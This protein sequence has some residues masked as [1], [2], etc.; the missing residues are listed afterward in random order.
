MILSQRFTAFALLALLWAH[1]RTAHGATPCAAALQTANESYDLGRFDVIE[2][3]LRPCLD[4]KSNATRQEVAQAWSLAARADLAL[5]KEEDARQAVD[6][7]LRADPTVDPD[8]P[9]LF[10]RM[11][12]EQRRAA[13]T[14][15]VS[16]VSK[17]AETF[18]E[19][20]ATVAVVTGEEIERRGYLDLEEM[21]H[22]LPGF[23]IS[24]GNGQV[25]STYY[26]RGFRSNNTD[27]NLLLVDGLEQNDLS[28]NVVY[29]SRQ[30]ALS[31][32]DRV[33]VLYGPAA[34]IYGAN[35]YTGVINIVTRDPEDFIP[36]GRLWGYS[37]QA[38]GGSF[39][40][41]YGDLS[42]AGRDRSSTVSW[43]LTGRLFR[44][45]ESS[46]VPDET[47]DW[48]VY[49][50][51]RLSNVTLGVQ[52]WGLREGSTPWYTDRSVATGR[53]AN[54]WA[55]RHTSLFFRTA[56][57]LTSNLTVSAFGQY[58]DSSLDEK[59]TRITLLGAAQPVAITESA[60]STQFK[61]E[62]SLSYQPLGKLGASGGIDIRKSLI[63]GKYD[64]SGTVP[65]ELQDLLGT[66][67]KANESNKHTE[68]TDLGL[69]V[70]ATYALSDHFRLTAAGR[71]DTEQIETIQ[72][73]SS[74]P[75]LGDLYTKR[76]ALIYTPRPDLVLKAIY[77][78]AFKDPS[79]FE[80]FGIEPVARWFPSDNLR[81]E[82]VENYEITALWQPASG[83]SITGSAYQA[84][85]RNV[86]VLESKTKCE[87]GFCL[88]SNRLVNDGEERIRGVQ[89][90][91]RYRARELDLYFNST[92][93]A[94]SRPE[95]NSLS[96]P[97]P[98]A[99]VG[100]I[101]RYR[102]NLGASRP[103]WTRLD[104]SLRTNWVGPR[105]TGPGT[106]VPLNPRHEIDSYF[107]AH[108]TLSYTVIPEVTLQLVVNNLFDKSYDDPG[109]QAADGVQL[110]SSIP[111]P[112]RTIYLRLLTGPGRRRQSQ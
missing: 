101:A 71:L 103:L 14:R 111:Q 26:Q 24:R 41:R 104:L 10:V 27:R 96:N 37:A 42:L 59:D 93:T 7:L 72:S 90:D 86:V 52:L 31:N 77:S 66:I 43:S 48:S 69:Y 64:I 4:T 82:K 21:L 5:D 74:S 81:P 92:V 35:A 30:Y 40:T 34:T 98:G 100:D 15:Q 22:D 109:V 49:G 58:L 106:T 61:G 46:P 20:P 19:A 2:D 18:R 83:L 53:D 8:E 56:R 78:D 89:I 36:E 45:D 79:D 12:K 54:V 38:G 67:L 108:A 62:L 84:Q 47:D 51:L 102:F 23:D 13:A 25:Y 57:P 16:S 6:R 50:R 11:V 65:A 95:R 3:Q 99:Q 70:Q 91:A 112:G 68:H 88:V 28:S 97:I 1:P 29:L 32:V 55:P 85:Y 107:V 39:N 105:K 17:T 80:K 9:P 33:E 44:S 76:A 75:S 73:Q 63:Q 87:G 60:F 110:A 94:A